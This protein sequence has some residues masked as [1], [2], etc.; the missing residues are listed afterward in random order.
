MSLIRS[1]RYVEIKF[2]IGHEFLYR[3]QNISIYIVQCADDASKRMI[4]VNSATM[5]LN[6][7][8]SQFNWYLLLN[9]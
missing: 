4:R 3:I 6:N 1:I 5:F 9:E 8:Y 7:N 2:H